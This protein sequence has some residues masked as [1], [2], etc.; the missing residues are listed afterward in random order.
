MG[1]APSN[2]VPLPVKRKWCVLMV[3]CMDDAQ[4]NYDARWASSCKRVAEE[5][6][7]DRAHCT[8][9]KEECDSYYK[10]RDP[11][12]NCALPLMLANDLQ[13][14]VETA[15]GRCSQESKMGTVGNRTRH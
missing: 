13:A 3:R 14:D 5:T 1:P 10:P 9:S 2:V 4:R 8:Y 11:S 7:A 6:I 15:R 12:P